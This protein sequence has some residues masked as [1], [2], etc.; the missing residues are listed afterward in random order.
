MCKI[1]FH[2]D[3]IL[4]YEK[5]NVGMDYH[6]QNGKKFGGFIF[7]MDNGLPTTRCIMVNASIQ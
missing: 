6:I 4:E 3:I 7:A 5:C 2:K 1:P